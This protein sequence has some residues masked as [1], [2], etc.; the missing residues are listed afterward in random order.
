M[1]AL[2]IL[3]PRSKSRTRRARSG[4]RKR[5]PMTAKQLK[6]FGPR[7]S[8]K[9]AS[10]RKAKA[11]PSVVIVQSNPKGTSMAKKR[12]HRRRKAAKP[13]THA[14]RYRRN[15]RS[16]EAGF[17]KNTLEPAAIG[18]AG[19][20]AANY[21]LTAVPLPAQYKTGVFGFVAQVAAAMAVG[22]A[23]GKISNREAGEEAAA[24]GVIVAV[25]G[26][27]RGFLPANMTAG[28]ARYVPMQRYV[29]MAAW[30]NAPMNRP[31]GRPGLGYANP[32]RIAGPSR[33]QMRFASTR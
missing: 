32:A 1:P 14:K 13:F 10:R 4:G 12:H 22:F 26:L 20:I 24:G 19:A 6:F 25:I 30:G 17:V 33:S 15:P 11:K 9:I 23:V 29:P 16:I 21:L 2:A 5:R 28:M 3:N 18:A 7:K 8:R 31:Q 27:A